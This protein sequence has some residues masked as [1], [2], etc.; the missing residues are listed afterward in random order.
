MTP[1]NKELERTTILS[2]AQRYADSA[3]VTIKQTDMDYFIVSITLLYESQSVVPGIEDQDEVFGAINEVI[4]SLDGLYI[5]AEDM[6]STT[7]DM[8]M[9]NEVTDYVTGLP[10]KSG[11]PSPITAL[12]AIKALEAAL[13]YKFSDK[14]FKNYS[15]AIQGA[16]STGREVIRHFIDYWRK[17]K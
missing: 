14:T 6:N 17:I 16:G 8:V 9:I 7:E 15:Y 11:D 4:E 1:Y 12:G 13:T 3:E 5:T 10:G 2:R